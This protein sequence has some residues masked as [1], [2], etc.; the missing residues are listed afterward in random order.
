MFFYKDL[1]TETEKFRASGF[2]A[3]SVGKSHLGQDIPYI[4][5]G[6]NS[7]DEDRKSVIITGGIHAREH[8]TVLL[9]LALAKAATKNDYKVRTYFVPCVNPDGMRLATE[10]I[11]FLDEKREWKKYKRF[12]NSL[13]IDKK[14]W[15]AN[16][17]GVDLNVNFDADWAQGKR[18]VFY[19]SP[20]NYVGNAPCDQPES[21]ALVDFTLAVRPSLTLSYHSKGEV[22]YWNFRQTGKRLWRD[23]GYAKRI[24]KSTGYRL[25]E[26]EGSAGG[27]KDWCIDKL[28]IP[29]V[30]IEVGREELSHPLT[31][32]NF[33]EIYLKNSSVLYENERFLY[34]HS[35]RKS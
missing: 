12:V 19:P 8:I 35:L 16:I 21:K 2:T 27:Y 24:A 25:R 1:L 4:A 29:S 7:T 13:S 28:K 23:Y 14:L 6:G 32:E 26:R 31:T 11:S 18:N 20:E 17:T 9:V 33:E 34:P 22:I 30:T 5:V 10:G 3:G 15:K